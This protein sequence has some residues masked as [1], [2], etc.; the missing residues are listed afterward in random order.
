MTAPETA[1]AR[2]MTACLLGLALG[3]WY[4]FLRPLRP[5]H[6]VLSDGLFILGAV[7]AWLY[8]SFAVCSG[9]LRLGYGAGLA[10]GALLWEMTAGRLLR[11]PFS[12]FWGKISRIKRGFFNKLKKF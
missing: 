5:K 4:G 6:T 1:A 8:V 11:R 10:V 3:L 12:V 7:W 9:D 2:L